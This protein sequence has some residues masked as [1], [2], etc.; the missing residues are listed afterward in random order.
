MAFVILLALG[1][2]SLVL[3]IWSYR[4][5]HLGAGDGDGKTA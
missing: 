4:K 3:T 1:I 5:Q 2:S